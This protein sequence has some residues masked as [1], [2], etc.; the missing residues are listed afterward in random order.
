VPVIITDVSV[1]CFLSVLAVQTK[2]SKFRIQKQNRPTGTRIPVDSLFLKW[3]K[4]EF[5]E[6]YEVLV[7]YHL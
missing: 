1:V 2:T 5:I 4:I 3:G 7:A 6:H